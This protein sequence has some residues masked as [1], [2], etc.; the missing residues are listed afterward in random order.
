[1]TGI[2]TGFNRE[3]A[4]VD[5]LEAIDRISLA[6]R[7]FAGLGKEVKSGKLAHK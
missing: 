6:A 4:G 5:R 1:M 2:S 7:G 3:L